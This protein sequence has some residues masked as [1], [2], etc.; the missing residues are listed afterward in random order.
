M[1]NSLELGRALLLHCVHRMVSAPSYF[2]SVM[3]I[4]SAL[5]HEFD[6]IRWLLETEIVEIFIIR[7][8]I[9]NLFLFLD[10]FL[11]I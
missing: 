3:S 8:E 1:N 9:L 10:N 6:I 7:D 2:E 4:R 5:V 11:Y